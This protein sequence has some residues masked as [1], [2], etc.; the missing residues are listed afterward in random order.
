LRHSRKHKASAIFDA[1]RA[2]RE[3]FPKERFCVSRAPGRR[4]E[5]TRSAEGRGKAF[6]AMRGAFGVKEKVPSEENE[7]PRFAYFPHGL[8]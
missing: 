8:D 6:S 2:F 3:A 7:F 1:G 5:F 4:A